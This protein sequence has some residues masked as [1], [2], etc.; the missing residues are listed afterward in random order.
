MK[1]PL[2]T[3]ISLLFAFLIL[4]GILSAQTGTLAVNDDFALN[5]I[6]ANEHHLFGYLSLGKTVVINMVVPGDSTSW[7]YHSSGVLQQLYEISGQGGTNEMVVLYIAASG[8]LLSP[9]LN[10]NDVTYMDYSSLFGPGY[11]SLSF[12][13]NNPIPIILMDMIPATFWTSALPRTYVICPAGN[14]TVVNYSSYQN[15][16][17]LMANSCCLTTYSYDPGLSQS[18]NLD[19]VN[20]GAQM[21]HYSLDN[22]GFLAMESVEINVS[23][24]GIFIETLV[25]NID[26][27]ACSSLNLNY[28]NNTLQ[29]GDV[30]T[31]T[32]S[33]P[34]INLINDE[35]SITY[36]AVQ[37]LINGNIRITYPVG[38]A[39][40]INGNIS[41]TLGNSFNISATGWENGIGYTDVFL[42]VADCYLLS[43]YTNIYDTI[44]ATTTPIS[45]Y[46]LDN[47][48]N[49]ATL[50][51]Q[52]NLLIDFLEIYMQVNNDADPFYSGY[53]FYDTNENG[54]LNPGEVGIAGIEVTIGNYTTFT[55]A[56]GYYFFNNI[57]DNVIGNTIIPGYDNL[58]WPVLTTPNQIIQLNNFNY[59]I[60]LSNSA[61]VYGAQ[62]QYLPETWFM[63]SE[64]ACFTWIVQ[65]TGN[66]PITAELIIEPDGILNYTQGTPFTI[67][68]DGNLVIETSN[69]NAGQS[70]Q[71]QLCSLVPGA[72]SLGFPITQSYD[73]AVFDIDNNVVTTDSETN[74]DIIYCSF[75]PND[76][77][78]YPLGDG[79]QHF[80]AP[81]TEL[82]YRI[83]FQNTGNFPA[84]DVLITD[85]LS[86]NLDWTTFQ[87]ISASH[88]CVPVINNLIGEITFTFS[89]IFLPDSASDLEGSQGFVLF[90]ISPNTDLLPLDVIENTA[91]IYFD[92][93]PAI[94]TNT[95]LHTISD[96]TSISSTFNSDQFLLFPNPAQ[97]EI[98]IQWIDNFTIWNAELIN[99]LGQ[100]TAI[101]SNLTSGNEKLNVSSQARG[102]YL[103][104]MWTDNEHESA[105]Q[106][107]LIL[108]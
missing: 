58:V 1:S 12:V 103:L 18:S 94:V 47:N 28:E 102:F 91:L 14:Y 21:I 46:D 20:C 101:F 98:N 57:T 69:I 44:P 73:L 77:T 9:T 62:I 107:K 81:Q 106:L 80:I 64:N 38:A 49:P 45:V 7:G 32:V 54:L 3:I 39:F 31:L 104:R 79:E 67:N 85:L 13:E 105:I 37:E 92:N 86:E 99:A 11:E 96:V 23:I 52:S 74:T 71:I 43:L 8:S 50:L 59:H 26:L 82:T 70:F 19:L 87:F 95:S 15:Y 108:R 75:D 6:D 16:L 68:G 17:N 72:D 76:K 89:N 4:T 5:D 29:N 10:V 84:Q 25:L 78:G 51:A 97:D 90:S 2:I 36:S 40:F 60:G 66:Q 41:G 42:N 33:S 22:E 27:M 65:N 34:N 24:N 100:R 53:V 56:N 83:R 55:D 63:C 48:G 93:N 30:V 35:V 88:S 61:P